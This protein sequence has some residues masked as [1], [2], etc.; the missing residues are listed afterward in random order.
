MVGGAV[1]PDSTLPLF[2]LPVPNGRL[3]AIDL[4]DVNAP[5]TNGTVRPQ[6]AFDGIVDRYVVSPKLESAGMAAAQRLP[7]DV[8]A[9]F[10]ADPRAAFKWVVGSQ[11]DLDAVDRLNRSLGVPPERMWL[12]PEADHVAALERASPQVAAAAMARGW[13]FSDRLHLR[14]YGA[15]RGI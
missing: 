6:P 13:Q 2:L 9:T 11:T 12:M 10:A 15:G 4:T 1:C 14:L 7:P 8:L 5:K 3:K